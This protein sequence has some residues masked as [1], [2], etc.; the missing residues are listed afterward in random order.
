MSDLTSFAFLASLKRFV[1]RR[2]L[3]KT[4]H[5]DNGRNFVGAQNELKELVERLDNETTQSNIQAALANVG[6]EWKFN[7]PYAPHRGGH[8]HEQ[9]GNLTTT[10]NFLIDRFDQ[11]S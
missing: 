5:S 8:I 11:Y 4:I 2:G 7:V 6:I 9:S 3:C 1:A 10:V